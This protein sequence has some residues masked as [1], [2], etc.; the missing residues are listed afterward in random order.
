MI[1]QSPDIEA[2]ASWQRD[3]RNRFRAGRVER[4][5]VRCRVAR[6]SQLPTGDAP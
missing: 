3:N 5:T 6:D 2:P 1:R 4:G